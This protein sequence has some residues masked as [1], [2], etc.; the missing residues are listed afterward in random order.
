MLV[1]HGADGSAHGDGHEG[2]DQVRDGGGGCVSVPGDEH[3]GEDAAEHAHGVRCTKPFKVKKR[4]WGVK[5]SG[6]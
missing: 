1:L 5:K 2:G 4:V 3:D 6:L